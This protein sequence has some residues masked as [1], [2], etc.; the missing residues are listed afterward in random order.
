MKDL[1]LFAIY[2]TRLSSCGCNL[3]TEIQRWF[4][5]LLPKPRLVG[6]E[7]LLDKIQIQTSFMFRE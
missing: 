6:I 4:W 1:A 2:F 5:M 7:K 3:E